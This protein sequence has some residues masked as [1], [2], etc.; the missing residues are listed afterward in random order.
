MDTNSDEYDG[1]S[2][3][4]EH[5][6]DEYPDEHD[7]ENYHDN[8]LS[9]VNSNPRRMSMDQYYIAQKTTLPEYEDLIQLHQP[10][11]QELLTVQPRETEGHE[12]LPSYSSDLSLEN[13]FMKKMELEGAV[14]R[15]DDRNWNR[16][17]VTLQGTALKFYKYKSSLVFGTRPEFLDDCPDLP[18]EAKKGECLRSYSLHLADAGIAADYTKFVARAVRMTPADRSE[19]EKSCN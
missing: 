4:E 3:S 16:V 13:V 1:D 15:A 17:F 9:L 18:V 7:G 8:S 11:R 14:H 12:V 6:G 10:P 5:V 19:Q 2:Y